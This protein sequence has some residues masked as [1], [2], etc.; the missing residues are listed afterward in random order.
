MVNAN[1]FNT[2]TNIRQNLVV[3]NSIHNQIELNYP[4]HDTNIVYCGYNIVPVFYPITIDNNIRSDKSQF[5][6]TVEKMNNKW[7]NNISINIIDIV[8]KIKPLTTNWPLVSCYQLFLPSIQNAIGTKCVLQYDNNGIIQTTLPL[9][10]VDN[11][12]FLTNNEILLLSTFLKNINSNYANYRIL[13]YI[14]NDIFYNDNIVN[15]WINNIDFFI[16]PSQYINS[17]LLIKNYNYLQY[18]HTNDTVIYSDTMVNSILFN[19]SEIL[20]NNVNVPYITNEFTYNH[21]Y[22]IVYR[23]NITNINNQINGF[24]NKDNVDIYFGVN[25]NI[26]LASLV[27]LGKDYIKYN[28]LSTLD[29]YNYE[30]VKYIMNIIDP[31]YQL[32]KAIIITTLTDTSNKLDNI[33]TLS[34]VVFTQ[35][36]QI[37]YNGIYSLN[38][39]Q[40]NNN[41]TNNIYN[42]NPINQITKQLTNINISYDF[43][44]VFNNNI[45]RSD[46]NY[47]LSYYN[48]DIIGSQAPIAINT[49]YSN[50]LIFKSYY[51]LKSTDMFRITQSKQYNISLVLLGQLYQINFPLTININNISNLYFSGNK[52]IVERIITK[53]ICTVII[54]P[55]VLLSTSNLFEIRYNI[56]IK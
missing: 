3:D 12:Y 32:N 56:M 55:S 41:Q 30:P 33:N 35:D 36:Q 23:N 31:S 11:Y 1:I 48:G 8:K 38:N 27:S 28:E 20:F 24:I 37:I 22:K 6:S 46:C 34:Y 44:L 14:E 9:S 49:Y 51:N 18:N 45:I 39:Y 43:K 13:K 17:Y 10:I 19:D 29:I 47:S 2:N 53:N 26:L 15:R 4:I 42:L 52:L 21:F 7:Q 40:N 50:E 25:I 16:N 54:P 5:Y